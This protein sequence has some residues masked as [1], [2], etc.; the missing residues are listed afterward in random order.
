MGR[1]A[2]SPAHA[3]TRAHTHV[4]PRARAIA[5]RVHSPTPR[6]TVL[7]I[8]MPSL[9]GTAALLAAA[10]CC[11][12]LSFGARVASAGTSGAGPS[13]SRATWAH[14]ATS[15]SPNSRGLGAHQLSPGACHRGAVC[16]GATAVLRVLVPL[17]LPSAAPMP[18]CCSGTCM[19]SFAL[20]CSCSLF[21]RQAVSLLSG[22]P[23]C[24]CAGF[25]PSLASPPP[26]VSCA[27]TDCACVR[28]RRL[29][30]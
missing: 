2:P 22:V 10:G 26:T 23:C 8:Y 18:C 5:V 11:R 4:H 25:C 17:R 15:R 3:H 13:G 12:V 1:L 9:P 27:P 20:C 6:A 28:V 7:Y 16:H 29:S 24:F 19:P 14:R 30:A 21:P